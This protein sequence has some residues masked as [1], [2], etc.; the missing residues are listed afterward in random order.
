MLTPPV[1]LLPA[2]EA[3]EAA[4][5]AASAHLGG[6]SMENPRGF[7]LGGLCSI[8]L[9]AAIAT[10]KPVQLPP[11]QF[12]ADAVEQDIVGNVDGTVRQRRAADAIQIHM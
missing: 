3:L 10:A 4:T 6:T 9:L 11:Q 5:S 2:T 1:T 12:T 7:A 8:L